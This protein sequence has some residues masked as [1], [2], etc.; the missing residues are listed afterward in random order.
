MDIKEFAFRKD[1]EIDYVGLC[2]EC[3]HVVDES[4]AGYC[5]L[6][7]EA[8]HWSICGG[9]VNYD[10]MDRQICGLCHFEI[11]RDFLNA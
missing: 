1:M 7:G 10:G 8:F 3:D 11:A 6:C 2:S 4:D 9:W 5:Y